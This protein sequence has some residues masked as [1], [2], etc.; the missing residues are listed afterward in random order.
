[1]SPDTTP[2]RPETPPRPKATKNLDNDATKEQL[3]ARHKARMERKKQLRAAAYASASKNPFIYANQSQHHEEF[4]ETP[5]EQAER[6]DAKHV[7]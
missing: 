3:E 5:K 2:A 6:M 7:L 4:G 1:M